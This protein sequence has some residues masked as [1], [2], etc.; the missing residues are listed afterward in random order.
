[1]QVEQEAELVAGRDAERVL[2]ERLSS[3]RRRV[4][5]SLNEARGADG[6]RARIDADRF[7]VR[8]PYGDPR[9]DDREERDD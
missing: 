1:V 4:D 5:R 2:R 6:D 7:D 8:G 9:G 3:G